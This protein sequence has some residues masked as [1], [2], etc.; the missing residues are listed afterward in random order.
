MG[1]YEE[2][3]ARDGADE[4]GLTVD[5]IE[6]IAVGPVDDTGDADGSVVGVLVING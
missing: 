1:P 4:D 2:R 3:G 6:G 5:F